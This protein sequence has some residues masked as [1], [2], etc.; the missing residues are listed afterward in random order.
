MIGS[1]TRV[2]VTPWDALYV[3]SAYSIYA[4]RGSH[5]AEGKLLLDGEYYGHGSFLRGIIGGIEI[6]PHHPMA[7]LIKGIQD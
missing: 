7:E 4:I 5:H 1:N 3:H 6:Q 2:T